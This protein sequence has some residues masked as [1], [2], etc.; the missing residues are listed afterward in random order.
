MQKVTHKYCSLCNTG[1]KHTQS[2]PNHILHFIITICTG[3]GW[4]VFWLLFSVFKGAETCDV[5]GQAEKKPFVSVVG[6][7]FILLITA[8]LLTVIVL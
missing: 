8:F 6:L 3:G 1:T 7:I 2:A 4:L 5:C